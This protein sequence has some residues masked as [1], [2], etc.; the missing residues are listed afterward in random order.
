MVAAERGVAAPPWS[1][2]RGRT[3]DGAVVPMWWCEIRIRGQ[4]DDAWSVW[5]D[6]LV[7][8]PTPAGETVL[9]GELPDQAALH[10]ALAKIRDLGLP[11]LG[12]TCD[13]RDD[14]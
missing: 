4:L 6:G 1:T 9:T 10:G 3:P 12:V 11:L 13:G 8:A 5:F 7:V 14:H 2:A